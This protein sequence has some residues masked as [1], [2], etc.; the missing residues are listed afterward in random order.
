MVRFEAVLF[1]QL[2]AAVIAATVHTLIF[3]DLGMVLGMYLFYVTVLWIQEWALEK[4][5]E[6]RK[7]SDYSYG[8][9]TGRRRKSA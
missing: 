3:K 6:R 2:S 5:R 4:F 8:D 7:H 1:H 9:E